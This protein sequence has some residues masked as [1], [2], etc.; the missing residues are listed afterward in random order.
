[1]LIIILFFHIEIADNKP[2]QNINFEATECKSIGAMLL[3][4]SMQ[5]KH[6]I[7]DSALDDILSIVNLLS[8]EMVVPSSK[9]LFANMF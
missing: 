2:T 1:M 7:T 3:L 6:G 4:L 8:N 5:I 9:Y